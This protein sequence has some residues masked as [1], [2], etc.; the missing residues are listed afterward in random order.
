MKV[1]K[2]FTSFVLVM[3]LILCCAMPAFAAEVPSNDMVEPASVTAETLPAGVYHTIYSELTFRNYYT[4]D[5]Y[6][7][8]GRWLNLNFDFKVADSDNGLGGIYLTIKVYDATTGELLGQ[9]VEEAIDKGYTPHVDDMTFDLG[10]S[11]R[12]VYLVIDAS[13]R[14]TSN[15]NYRSAT[16][17]NFQ[18]YVFG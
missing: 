11:G 12:T 9:D 4:T 6:Y 16:L 14:G 13:S 3:A 8:Q 1:K 18:S 5:D 10:T 17:Y 7:V 15:G 2:I